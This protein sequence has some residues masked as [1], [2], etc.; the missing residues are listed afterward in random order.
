MGGG[1][2]GQRALLLGMAALHRRERVDGQQLWR[3]SFLGQ[4][5]SLA[6]AQILPAPREQSEAY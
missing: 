2:A 4:K 3:P 1:P 6:R 5:Q